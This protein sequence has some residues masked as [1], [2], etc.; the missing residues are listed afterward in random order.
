MV[1]SLSLYADS[2]FCR[3]HNE[4]NATVLFPQSVN[5]LELEMCCG[6]A[7]SILQKFWKHV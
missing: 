1:Q 6:M 4:V 5:E 2:F 7:M 3:K